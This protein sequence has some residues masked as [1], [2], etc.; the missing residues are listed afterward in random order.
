[1]AT[2]LQT[3]LNACDSLSI[4][5]RRVAGIQFARNEQPRISQTPTLNPWK[6]TLTMPNSFRYADSRNLIE[7]LDTLDRFTPQLITFSSNP[8]L[9]WFF[10]YQGTMTPS[11]IANIT[12]TSY[13]GDQLVLGNL[14]VLPSTR[15][16][17]E[18][19][20]LIQIGAVDEHPFPFT[21]NNR[22]LRGTGATVTL[23]TSRPNIITGSVVGDS[24]IVGNPCQFYMF[25]P[26]MPTYK[27]MP[28]GWQ[29]RG[30]T[31]INNAYLEWSDDFALYEWV[32]TA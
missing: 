7:T 8:K 23:T 29:V 30:S 25:C 2:G 28:G 15:V 27:F 21:S 4:D 19:N 5:R 20:D 3:I 10:R 18:P 24:I 32:A 17:F 12:V 11:Q 16:L 6:M 26:N 14:P 31:T 22:V 13:V 1:M 9:S